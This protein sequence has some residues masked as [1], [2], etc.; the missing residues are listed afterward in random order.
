MGDAFKKLQKSYHWLRGVELRPQFPDNVLVELR[1]LENETNF[2]KNYIIEDDQNS[3]DVD[4]HLQRVLKYCVLNYFDMN[5]IAAE[6]LSG[7]DNRNR[8][9][10]GPSF[11]QT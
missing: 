5:A 11:L 4:L 6:S 3:E 2:F 8:E 10:E 9:G 1:R 7:I